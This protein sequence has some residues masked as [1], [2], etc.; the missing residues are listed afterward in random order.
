METIHSNDY[1][2][3]RKEVIC[4]VGPEEPRSLSALARGLSEM[5]GR[6]F[7][8]YPCD[9]DSRL[10]VLTCHIKYVAYTLQRVGAMDGMLK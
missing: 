6:G 10:A 3:L 5:T 7:L 2:A 9:E 4:K 8:T 1:M